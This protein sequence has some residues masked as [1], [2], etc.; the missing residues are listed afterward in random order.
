MSPWLSELFLGS[1]S[2]ERLVELARAGHDRAF[3]AIVQR[4]RRE[5]YGHARRLGADGHAEDIVQQAFLS[6]FAALRKDTDVAHL[7]GWLYTIVRHTAAR[8]ARGLQGE[9]ELDGVVLGG[10]RAVGDR[11]S[12]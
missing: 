3:V 10:G 4:Y 2:D 7:R 8:P 12:P 1:Q 5:L 11:Q 9:A 6:A